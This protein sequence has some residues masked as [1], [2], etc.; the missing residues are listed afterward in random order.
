MKGP[1]T[2]GNVAQVLQ[3]EFS[4]P[5]V[6]VTPVQ[7]QRSGGPEPWVQFVHYYT[8]V[9]GDKVTAP[10][11]DNLY[12]GDNDCN[13]LRVFLPQ[14]VLACSGFAPTSGTHSLPDCRATNC[15]FSLGASPCV[16]ANFLGM[17]VVQMRVW[18]SAQ[19]SA[20]QQSISA[21]L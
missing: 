19:S 9:A 11:D 16:L 18:D 17:C 20:R 21:S 8:A 14:G 2:L 1:Q 4:V 3:A 13:P 12:C 10:R 7:S 6:A 15:H 5:I